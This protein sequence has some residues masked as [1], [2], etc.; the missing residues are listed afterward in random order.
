MPSAAPSS[1]VASFIAEP[2][3]ARLAG[4]A[5]MIDAVIGDIDNAIPLTSGTIDSSTYQYGVC[6]VSSRKSAMPTAIPSMPDA[7]TRFAPYLALRRGVSGETR[8]MIGAI[9]SKR[10]AALNGE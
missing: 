2:A 5:D 8:I 9:G 3:P 7:T 10:S 1:R 4:T 6:G